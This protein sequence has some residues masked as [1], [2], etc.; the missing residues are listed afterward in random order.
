MSGTHVACGVIPTHVYAMSGTDR[1]YGGTRRRAERRWAHLGT[2]SAYGCATQCP[3]LTQRLCA[4]DRD[5]YRTTTEESV[6]A[7][8]ARAT[9]CA[10]LSFCTGGT[11]LRQVPL[12]PAQGGAVQGRRRSLLPSTAALLPFKEAMLPF[13]E[14]ILPFM[15]AMLLFMEAMLLFM[16]C[17]ALVYACNA[18]V[19]E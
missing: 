14:S 9:R 6:S 1:A 4:A 7:Y 11:E 2:L 3:V 8:A 5:G 12:A 15:E 10:V 17:I 16:G 19:Y 18:A 13:K